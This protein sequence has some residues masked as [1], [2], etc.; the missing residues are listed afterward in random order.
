M[1]K[2]ARPAEEAWLASASLRLLDGQCSD[3]L[4]QALGMAGALQP[5]V[6]SAQLIALGEMYP[7][8]KVGLQGALANGALCVAAS[9]PV[10]IWCRVIAAPAT[11]P[12]LCNNRNVNR[13]D[14]ASM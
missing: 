10:L 8:P 5:V 7:S 13:G 4:L 1:P 11:W 9:A 3:Q 6:L 2:C 14:Q 12:A